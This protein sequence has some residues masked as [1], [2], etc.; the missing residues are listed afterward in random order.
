MALRTKPS[1]HETADR[2]RTNRNCCL[3]VGASIEQPWCQPFD[4]TSLSFFTFLEFITSLEFVTSH[5]WS[6]RIASLEF[7]ASLDSS[8]SWNSVYRRLCRIHITIVV[9]HRSVNYLSIFSV[10][11]GK[12]FAIGLTRLFRVTLYCLY[13]DQCICISWSHCIRM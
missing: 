9:V 2:N 8:H 1:S 4:F 11:H 13:S 5:R 3:A 10:V 6:R 12:I 7:V